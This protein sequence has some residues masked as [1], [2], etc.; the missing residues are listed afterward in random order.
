MLALG[1]LEG[2]RALADG[3]EVADVEGGENLGEALVAAADEGVDELA[4]EFAVAAGSARAERPSR[5]RRVRWIPSS[6]G[7][8]SPASWLGSKGLPRWASMPAGDAVF[9]VFAHDVG[10][11]RDDGQAL[12]VPFQTL[13][14]ADAAARR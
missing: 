12:A 8:G 1:A 5:R 9:A 11:E 3:F 2:V 13:G 7:R 10:G 14:F 6:S 4:L